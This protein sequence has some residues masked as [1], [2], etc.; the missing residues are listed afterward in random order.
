MRPRARPNSRVKAAWICL[1]T[2]SPA[3]LID[4]DDNDD[5]DDD[6]DDEGQQRGGMTSMRDNNDDD[7]GQKRGGTTSSDGEMRNNI[8]IHGSTIT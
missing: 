8:S 5:D 2:D 4:D 1:A 6:D 3:A 7:K